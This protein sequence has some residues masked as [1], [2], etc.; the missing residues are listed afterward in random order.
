MTKRQIRRRVKLIALNAAFILLCLVTLVPILYALSL[1]FSGNGAALSGG[2]SFL[3]KDPT[4]ANYRAILFDEPFLLWLK[5][6]LILSVGTIALAMVCAVPAAYAASRWRF[7][8]R[9]GMLRVLLVLNA[10]P[11]RAVSRAAPDG[12]SQLPRGPCGDLRGIHVRV[13]HMEHEGVF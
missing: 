2:L 5:N 9:R 12:P 11:V 3:P 4:L 8:G 6:S 10:F 13:R 1:S 7:P